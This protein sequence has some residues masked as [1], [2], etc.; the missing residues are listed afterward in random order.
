MFSSSFPIPLVHFFPSSSSVLWSPFLKDYVFGHKVQILN[1]KSV[2]NIGL[3]GGFLLPPASGGAGEWTALPSE[4]E[5][6]GHSSAALGHLLCE[7][8]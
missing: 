5:F 4:V 6:P 7:S 2:C 8:V 1:W 3:M